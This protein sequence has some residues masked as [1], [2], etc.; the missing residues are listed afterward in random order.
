MRKLF[1]F[2]WILTVSASLKAQSPSI[3]QFSPE[4]T[5]EDIQFL[6]S[7]LEDLHPGVY[8]FISKHSLDSCFEQTIQQVNGD[9]S[10]ME[11]L[12]MLIPLINQIRCG[13]TNL[14]PSTSYQPKQK[15]KDA[16]TTNLPKFKYLPVQLVGDGDEVMVVQ[17]IPQKVEP[18]GLDSLEIL[19]NLV[20]I[21]GLQAN[22]LLSVVS[23]YMFKDGFTEVDNHEKTYY[24]TN[25]YNVLYL[26]E[27][28]DTVEIVLK[29]EENIDT[30]LLPTAEKTNYHPLTSK[31]TTIDSN[32]ILPYKTTELVYYKTATK[33]IAY[34]ADVDLKCFAFGCRFKRIFK[35]LKRDGIDQLIVDFQQNTGGG[36]T[37]TRDFLEYTL[38]EPFYF[39]YKSN[40][41][42]LKNFEDH[43]VLGEKLLKVSS[44]RLMLGLS[45]KDNKKEYE[46]NRF[47]IVPKRRNNYIGELYLLV[48]G[49]T[50]SGATVISSVLKHTRG[51]TIIGTETRGV[52]H[53][54][55]MVYPFLIDLPNTKILINLPF[56]QYQFDLPD[57]EDSQYGRGV[58]PDV[59]VPFDV[60]NILVE[61]KHVAFYK[62]IEIIVDK[63]AKE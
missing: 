21:N 27:H 22:D 14:Y 17:K 59:I 52:E 4:Q 8:D 29:T 56:I 60:Q 33:P 43:I 5:K 63:Q 46:M 13:H 1:T 24:L 34:I 26:N 51:A 16:T 37:R 11:V 45:S 6:K 39:S 28:I 53:Q 3:V 32:W 50:F 61:R 58:Q 41:V 19:G 23:Q 35:Q 62:A 7:V 57:S 54:V 47:N 44:R 48:D 25:F 20:S 9:M 49:G 40:S 2:C 55:N 38:N 30:L 31:H 12:K 36:S 42:N 15:K 18:R 10:E